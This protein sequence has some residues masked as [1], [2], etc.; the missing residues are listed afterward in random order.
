[1]NFGRKLF[2]KASAR[3]LHSTSGCQPRVAAAQSELGPELTPESAECPGIGSKAVSASTGLTTLDS[4]LSSIVPVS[5]KIHSPAFCEA[6]DRGGS[7]APML[8][9]T[10]A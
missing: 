6:P 2:Q 9:T 10:P 1:M 8:W 5:I 4:I 7:S 3:A